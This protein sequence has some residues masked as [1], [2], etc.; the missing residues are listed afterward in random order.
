MAT[1]STPTVVDFECQATTDLTTLPH[2]ALSNGCRAWVSAGGSTQ[3]LWCLNNQNAD[4]IGPGVVATSDGIGR[5]I[6]FGAGGFQSRAKYGDGS[7]GPV[8]INAGT[9]VLARDMFYD[10]LVTA[11]GA[12]L[13][14]NGFRICSRKSIINNGTITSKG[15]DGANATPGPPTGGAATLLGTLGQGAKGSDG[16]ANAGGPAG[17]STAESMGGSGGQGGIGFAGAGYAAGVATAPSATHGT[18]RSAPQAMLGRTEGGA[19]TSLAVQGGAGGGGGCGDGLNS[20][21]G[22]AGGGGPLLIAARDIFNPGSIN[23]DGGKGGDCST[24]FGAGTCGGGGGGGGGPVWVICNGYLGNAPTSTGG[25]GGA[26]NLP[27]GGSDGAPGADGI[28]V[29]LFDQ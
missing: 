29:P 13:V 24:A 20:G 25:L 23:G 3:G 5:W 16:G 4:P 15:N 11:L 27:L 1:Q 22:A 10:S 21:G 7:D 6:F 14:T 28:V 19:S 12:I 9:T 8:V 17:D 26:G 18:A 2:S